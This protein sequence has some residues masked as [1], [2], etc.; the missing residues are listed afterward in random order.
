MASGGECCRLGMGIVGQA[1][2]IGS[3]ID[4]Q[5]KSNTHLITISVS[6]FIAFAC[7]N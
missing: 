1:A 5:I 4:Q 7:N 3:T 2:V 6:C